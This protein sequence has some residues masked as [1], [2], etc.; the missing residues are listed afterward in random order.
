LLGSACLLTLE[1]RKLY[2]GYDTIFIFR[3]SGNDLIMQMNIEMV[4]A[5]C[6]FK[7]VIKTIDD[8]HLVIRA[9]PGE[10]CF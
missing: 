3:R 2:G 5:L 6:G 10:L 8:R 4:E 1:Y 7:R 9:I